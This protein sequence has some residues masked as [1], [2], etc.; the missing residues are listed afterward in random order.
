MVKFTE[1]K[2][3]H[4]EAAVEFNK[5]FDPKDNLYSQLLMTGE[6][7]VMFP[8]NLSEPKRN[9]Q[10]GVTKYEITLGLDKKDKSTKQI[11]KFIADINKKQFGPGK[12]PKSPLKDGDE[13]YEDMIAKLEYKV[14]EGEMTEEELEDK[15]SFYECFKGMVYLNASSLFHPY[16]KSKKYEEPTEEL[17]EQPA[18]VDGQLEGLNPDDIWVGSIGR[19]QF[20]PFTY[21][22]D[23]NKGVSLGFRKYQKLSKGAPLGNPSS[24]SSSSSTSGF[25]KVA[26][27]TPEAPE[28]ASSDEDAFAE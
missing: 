21:N 10:G 14:E 18:T 28:K 22:R 8:H 2:K 3:A 20:N 6:A 12:G 27:A 1:N 5:E 19:L 13:F 23:G 25:S 15:K 16:F 9:K 24:G 11:Q 17:S 7:V 4:D 26:P